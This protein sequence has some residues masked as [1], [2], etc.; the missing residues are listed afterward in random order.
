MLCYAVHI[1]CLAVSGYFGAMLFGV[2]G[3]A[4]SVVLS[5]MELW[6]SFVLT[7]RK[8]LKV[9]HDDEKPV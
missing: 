9:E 2:A 5:K 8:A 3:F 4:A 7:L 6:V 1:V